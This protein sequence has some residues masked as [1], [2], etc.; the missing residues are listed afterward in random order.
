[1]ATDASAYTPGER[2]R[3][4]ELAYYAD[5]LDFSGDTFRIDPGLLASGGVAAVAAL[6]A[7]PLALLAWRTR[8]AAYVL[9]GAVPVL[10]VALVPALF[11]RFAD[12]VSLSQ[13]LRIRHF[14]P[15]AFALAG[16]ALLL[17]GLL[18]GRVRPEI[19]APVLVLALV[20]PT[21]VVR[22][23]AIERTARPDPLPDALLK[24]LDGR[25]QPRELVV[26]DPVTSYRLV[27]YV[28]VTI[29]A[30]PLAHVAQTPSD[31]PYDRLR[32]LNGFVA[33]DDTE[34]RRLLDALGAGWLLVDRAWL[35]G[36]LSVPGLEE[37]YDD[38]RFLLLR[39]GP[40]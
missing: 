21:L 4:Q 12:L 3:A 35:R 10:T 26:S 39:V 34:R 20:V 28:P 15:L 27:A 36:D 24:A 33:A 23:A 14:L 16:G 5:R 19:V 37:V 8:W 18:R 11:S 7:I 31:R 30:A 1:V 29:L 6:I 2:Q 32:E 9:G 17:A 13:A 22:A 40:G 38:G 25:A